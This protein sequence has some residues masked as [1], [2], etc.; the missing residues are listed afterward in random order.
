MKHLY[1]IFALLALPLVV[2]AGEPTKTPADGYPD[3]AMGGDLS[4]T[5]RILSD[6]TPAYYALDANGDYQL[7]TIPVLTYDHRFDAIRLRVW[8]NPNQTLA[9]NGFSAKISGSTVSCEATYGFSDPADLLSLAKTFAAQG[10]R[11]MVAFHLSDTW[12]DPL[13]QFIPAEWNDCSTVDELAACVTEHVTEVLTSLREANVN[14]AWVQIGNE[15][16]T[17]MLRCPMPSAS[18]GSV[19]NVNWG[20]EISSSNSTTT[21]NFVTLFQAGSDA[22]KA[23]YPE[24]KIVMQLA[25]AQKW[26]DAN[27]CLNLLKNNGFG[28]DMCDYIGLSLY[29]TSDNQNTSQWETNTS[30]AVTTIQNIYTNYGFRT[31]LCELGMNNEWTAALPNGTQAQGIAQCNADMEA[32]TTYLIEN[33]KDTDSTCDG[34]FYWEPECDYL[35]GYTMG[36]CVS[37]DPG[38]SWPR[39]KVTPNTYWTVVEANSDFPAGG[40]VDYEC[41]GISGIEADEPQGPATYYNI[42]GQSVANPASGLYIKSQGGVAKKVILP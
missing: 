40:L 15:T 25:N 28:S 33:L 8:V 17:G 34:F 36:A 6:G 31:L 27:W 12:A 22:A 29:P 26:S 18:G 42:Q 5:S 14:V 1:S 41:N 19:S 7:T 9:K 10:Q 20:G 23:V 2:S 37:I 39:N 30:A 4:W 13:R 16:S 24:A 35:G 32:F 3:F 38:T 21:K 11:I